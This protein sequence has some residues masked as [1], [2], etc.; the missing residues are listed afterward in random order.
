MSRFAVLLVLAGCSRPLVGTWEGTTTDCS[1][2]EIDDQPLELRIVENADGGARLSVSSQA[3]GS[4][5]LAC[6]GEAEVPARTTGLLQATWEVA[7]DGEELA[8]TLS[9]TLSDESDDTMNGSLG[10][11]PPDQTPEEACGFT[12]TRVD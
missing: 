10:W 12:V 3:T 5:P 2:P 8:Y 11:G 4:E 7:C 1:N 9:A 6:Q